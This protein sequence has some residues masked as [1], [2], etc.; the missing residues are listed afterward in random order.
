MDKWWWR[1]KIQLL[2]V[3]G[4]ICGW[5]HGLKK[6]HLGNGHKMSAAEPTGDSE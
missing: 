6:S 2:V 4:E 1:E 5:L 3:R